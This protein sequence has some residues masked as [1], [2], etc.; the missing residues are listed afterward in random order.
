MTLRDYIKSLGDGN[1]EQG[2][3]RFAEIYNIERRRAVSYLYQQR[4]PKPGLARRIVA[5][6]PVTWEGIYEEKECDTD[7]TSAA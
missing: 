3:T 4:F 7:Q 2:A 1:G 6:S 5:D